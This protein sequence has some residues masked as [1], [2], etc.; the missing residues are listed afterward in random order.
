MSDKNLRP[1]V[2]A[3]GYFDSVHKGHQK[4]IQTAR[5]YADKNDCSLTVFT[6]KGNLKAMLTGTDEK[7]VFLPKEREEI[8]KNLGADEIFFAPVDRKFL[9]LSRRSFLRKLNKKFN[10]AC[11]VCGTDYKFG[12][13]GKG[14]ITYLQ[15]WAKKKK[16]TQLIVDDFIVDGQKVSTTIVK[17][18]LTSGDIKKA[19]ELLGRPYSVTGT[20]F[21]DR[22]VGT[23]LGFP[24][25]NMRI[26]NEK[27]RLKEGVYAGKFDYDGKEYRAIINYG[28]RPTFDLNTCLIEA[29][30]I[31]F[32]GD[33][34]GKTVTLKFCSF[35]REIKKFN[36][37]EDLTAQL[38]IDMSGVKEGKYD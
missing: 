32:S 7:C 25:L 20:V 24:T 34:Y 5:E 30:V 6:F 19:N 23:D 26:D 11:Y 12:K 18:Y 2:I 16:K 29:H 22:T 33:L 13:F 15:K 17:E 14:D 36:G 9:S 3:L 1:T 28:G 35:I 10:I 4:V 38:A 8:L 37:I 27:H 21:R 31:D